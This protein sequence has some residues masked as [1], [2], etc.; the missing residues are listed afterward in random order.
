MF[1]GVFVSLMMYDNSLGGDAPSGYAEGDKYFVFTDEGTYAEVSK[2]IWILNYALWVAVVVFGLAAA[3]A[4]SVAV[5][6]DF[7]I[8]GY[9]NLYGGNNGLRH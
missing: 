5:L 3:I 6:I 4:L 2:S 1:I 9:R 8:P 7:M